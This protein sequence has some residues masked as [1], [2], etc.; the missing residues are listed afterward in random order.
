M[1]DLYLDPEGFLGTGASLI[2]DLTLVAYILL[3]LPAMITGYIFARRGM[4]RPQHR[5]M[6][7][8]ITIVNWILII[9]LM[10]VAYDYDVA[11]NISDNTGNGRYLLPT[12]HAI[13]GLPAQLMATYI[14]I[15]MLVEDNQVAKAK[16]R[17]EKN[18]EQYWFKQAKWMMRLTLVLWLATAILGIITYTIRYDVIDNFNLGDD[19]TSEAGISPVATEEAPIPQST[20]EALSVDTTEEAPAPEATG[21]ATSPDSTE[22]A[23][24]PDATEEMEDDGDMPIETEE[25]SAP[26]QTEESVDIPDP[27]QTEEPEN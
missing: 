9:V 26:A 22:D 6:M 27:S 24:M 18:L 19:D 21:D 5:Y 23:P 25:A 15:R 3:I 20:D 10:F 17:G 4:H 7:T 1:N 12:L 2:A 14:I 8:V 16:K 13:L 11:D